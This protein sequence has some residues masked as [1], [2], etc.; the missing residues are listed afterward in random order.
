MHSSI[1]FRANRSSGRF[2]PNSVSHSALVVGT[3]SSN[4]LQSERQEVHPIHKTVNTIHSKSNRRPQRTVIAACSGAPSHWPALAKADDFT[5]S[6]HQPRNELCISADLVAHDRNGSRATELQCPG[7]IRLSANN[8]GIAA[9]WQVTFR[10]GRDSRTA[11][12]S[13]KFNLMKQNS[14]VGDKTF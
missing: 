13:R 8:G 6:H 3:N 5:L 4:P 14:F 12:R 10:A 1:S 11:T 7:N 9:A 2:L